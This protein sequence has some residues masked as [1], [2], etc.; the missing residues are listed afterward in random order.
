MCHVTDQFNSTKHLHLSENQEQEGTEKHRQFV[1][2]NSS[3]ISARFL[4][5][6]IQLHTESHGLSC[7]VFTL[8]L[9]DDDDDDYYF[10]III[11]FAQHV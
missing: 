11:C 8:R 9:V 5:M 2:H 6:V 1:L 10:I 3:F 7:L 4:L